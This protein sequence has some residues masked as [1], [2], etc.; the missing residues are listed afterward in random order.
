MKKAMS[1]LLSL[2]LLAGSCGALAEDGRFDF[3]SFFNGNEVTI[4]REEY[5]SLKRFS[6]LAEVYSYILQYYYEEPNE[7]LMMEGAMWGML[8]GLGDNYTFYYT[9]E[10][11]QKMHEDDEGKYAGVG[12]QMLANYNTGIVTI[13]RVF[14][15]TPAEKAG[16]RKGDVLVRVDDLTVTADTMSDAAAL[17]RG[18]EADSVELEVQRQGENLVFTVARAIINVNWTETAMLDDNVGLLVLYEF[19]GDCEERVIAGVKELEEQGATA[20]ILDLRDNSGGWVEAAVKIADIFLDRQLLFYSENRAGKREERFTKSGRDDIP[21][22]ILVNG[23]SASSSEILSG[24]LQDTGRALLVGTQ[25]YGK[26]IMQ[27]VFGLSG[28]GGK[29]DGMQV[30][31]AQY[32]MPSG[33]KV[34][35]IGITPDVVIEMPEELVGEFFQL[36]DM[37]DPQLKLAWE[38][39]VALRNGE[40]ELKPHEPVTEEEQNAVED[41]AAA[42]FAPQPLYISLPM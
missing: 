35:K 23:S 41:D 27:Y 11:W 32:F 15:N 39:A 24:S 6:K 17:M 5:D 34:H 31:Y 9:P 13:S 42:A 18:K 10:N 2:M 14:K 30:T 38:K 8:E 19:S 25:T 37:A 12:I 22:V 36:G 29:D 4:S 1:L 26:G 33:R 21:L 20:L 40:I 16:V 7:E 3:F 28:A